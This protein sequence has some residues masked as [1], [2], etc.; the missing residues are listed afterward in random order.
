MSLLRSRGVDLLAAESALARTLSTERPDDSIAIEAKLALTKVKTIEGARIIVAQIEGGLAQTVRRWSRE[1]DSISLAEIAGQARQILRDS[2]TARLIVDGCTVA[3]VG[4]PNTGKSTLLNTLA[5]CE[6]AI[7]TDI[8]GTTRDWISAEILIPPLAATVIDTAGLG[9]DAVAADG[10]GIDQ[11]AQAR[12]VEILRRADLVLL[13]LDLSRPDPHMGE[14]LLE[15]LADKRVL[16]VLNKSDLPSR[17]DLA[18]LPAD[19][20]K[21]VR[22]SAKQAVGID[23]LVR[24]IHRTLGVASFDPHSPV[25]FTARQRTLL[26]R[27]AV[28]GMVSDAAAIV[29]DILRGPIQD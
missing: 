27:L 21:S 16:T 17:L 12:S 5:G 19:T 14:K 7:V 22:I 24:A 9:A 8:E 25:A 6:K 3:L 2:Q 20:D 11:A 29:A 1:K 10:D 18:A 13:V 28:T 23:D 26:G 4:P 15:A